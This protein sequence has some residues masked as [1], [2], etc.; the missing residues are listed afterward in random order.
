MLLASL[1]L[2]SVHFCFRSELEQKFAPVAIRRDDDDDKQPANL[3]EEQ[4]TIA[5][6]S[7]PTRVCSSSL[8]NFQR[9][10]PRAYETRAIAPS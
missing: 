8:F 9:H 3:D 6:S 5:A 7:W 2:G 4:G 10:L 1:T